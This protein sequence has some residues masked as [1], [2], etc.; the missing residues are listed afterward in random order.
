MFLA[1]QN[2]LLLF[3]FLFQPLNITYFIGE[4]IYM[5]NIKIFKNYTGSESH[6]IMSNS[7]WPHGLYSPWNSSGQNSE[8]GSLFLLQWISL[9]GSNPGLLHCRRILY[10]PSH[11]QRG[12]KQGPVSSLNCPMDFQS[13]GNESPIA[14]P[15]RGWGGH[16][17]SAS[18]PSG[19]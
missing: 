16:L 6:S 12:P 10:C 13:T 8:V 2:A 11:H 1:R 4:I 19:F 5:H 15:W 18:I 17:P 7:M 3:R 14:L 9:Q